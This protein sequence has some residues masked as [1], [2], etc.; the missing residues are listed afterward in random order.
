VLDWAMVRSYRSGE[1]PARWK[2][3]LENLLPAKGKV[4]GTEHHAALP[5]AEIGAFMADL[6]RQ[7][8]AAARALEFA[9]LTAARRG[10][11][12]GAR[13]S[14]FN[15]AERLWTVP[16]ARMKAGAEHRVA[17][18]DAAVAIVE[19]MPRSGEFVF[20]G[21]K[22]G[23]PLL[24]VLARMK[25]ADLTMHG[26]RSTF[27]DWAAEQTAFPTEVAE[28]ALAH[29][30]GSKVEQAYRRTDQFQ[31]RRQLADAWARFCALPGAPAGI[32]VPLR[33]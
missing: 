24:A 29:K 26:F 28:L 30:V 10:E 5:Y 22:D 1:N 20:P 9:I 17:L 8:G 14:E 27:A 13:W 12:V 3:H 16:A 25:R 6:R 11:V 4:A 21:M 31:R 23:K 32:V 33:A 19:Q 7:E 15:L 2:G 18:S